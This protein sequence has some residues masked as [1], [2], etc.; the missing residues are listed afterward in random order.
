MRPAVRVVVLIPIVPRIGGEK[1]SR[2]SQ[3]NTVR[4]EKTTPVMAKHI[5]KKLKTTE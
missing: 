5:K 3:A 2:K 4:D 1:D